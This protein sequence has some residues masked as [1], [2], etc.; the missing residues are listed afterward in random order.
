MEKTDCLPKS[1][2]EAHYK[3]LLMVEEPQAS[4]AHGHS[5]GVASLD[6][7]VICHG[8]AWLC[9]ELDA[10]LRSMVNRVTEREECIRGNRYSVQSLQEFGLLVIGQWLR[11][12]QKI[13]F[14]LCA[15]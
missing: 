4:E 11:W 9:D 15:L 1:T 2:V 5:I 6:H 8:A 3:P 7:F 13:L 14:P 10:Q 12:C